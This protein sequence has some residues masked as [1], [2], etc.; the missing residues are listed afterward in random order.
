MRKR[1]LIGLALLLVLGGIGGGLYWKQQKDEDKREQEA[2]AAAERKEVLEKYEGA[3]AEYKDLKADYD[4]FQ[5]CKKQLTPILESLSSLQSRLRVGLVFGSYGEA[6]GRIQV[7]YDR[8][9]H[10]RLSD[11]CFEEVREPARKAF[12]AYVRANNQW[13]SCIENLFSC[14]IDGITPDLREKWSLA[15]KLT[16]EAKHALSD[17]RAS[18]PTRPKP[19]D[20]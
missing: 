7:R 14:S 13:N 5:F 16:R 6:V 15:S 3:L 8:I 12:N 17:L 2:R 19:P 20:E 4:S 18:K 11:E 9:R 10:G 1:I